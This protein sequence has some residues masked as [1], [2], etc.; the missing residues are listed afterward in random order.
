MFL[1]ILL[2]LKCGS[3]NCR[4][5]S[6]LVGG[7]LMLKRA[8]RSGLEMGGTYNP[9]HR[10]YKEQ[11]SEEGRVWPGTPRSPNYEVLSIEFS[12]MCPKS[13]PHSREKIGLLC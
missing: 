10:F 13:F 7:F 1:T 9:L 12:Q 4:A 6:E 11:N 5:G 8:P 2:L 3:D